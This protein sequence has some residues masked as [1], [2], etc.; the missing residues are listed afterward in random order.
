MNSPAALSKTQALAGECIRLSGLVQGVGMRPSIYRLATELQLRGDVA[1]CG[2]DVLIQIWAPAPVLELFLETLFSHLPPGSRIDQCERQALV[3]HPPNKFLIQDSRPRSNSGEVH[4]SGIIPDRAICEQCIAELFQSDNRRYHHPF[5]NCTSCGPRF[6]I[7]KAQTWERSNTSMQSFPLCSD[8]QLEFNSPLD[9]RFQAHA[10]ACPKC[11]PTLRYRQNTVDHQSDVIALAAA[12]IL[13][14][15]IV[16]IQGQGCFQL[17]CHA[18][19]EAAIARLR[20]LKQRAQKPFALM[21]ESPTD[22]DPYAY[23]SAAEQQLLESPAAPI[24]LLKTKMDLLASEI[25]PGLQDL[26]FMLANTALHHLILTVIK[27]PIVLTSANTSAQPPLYKLDQ[28]LQVLDSLCDGIVFHDRAIT[29]RLDDSVAQ[30]VNDVPRLLRRAR[31]YVPAATALPPGFEQCPPTLA[32]GGHYKSS[33]CLLSDRHAVLSAWIG[34]LN[35]PAQCEDYQQQLIDFSAMNHF[36]PELLTCDQHPD[37]F[38][39][40]QAAELASETGMKL[41]PVWHHHAHAA[42]CLAENGRALQSQPVLAVV[43]DGNGLGPDGTIWGGEFLLVDYQRFQRLG[44]ITQFPL[45]GGE[46]AAQQPWRSLLAQL[47]TSLSWSSLVDEFSDLAII[48]LLAAKPI[49]TLEGM[50]TSHTNSPLCSSVGRLFDAVAAALE[51]CFEKLSYEGEAAMK[52]QALAQQSIDQG[53]YPIA[54]VDSIDGSQLAFS[55]MWQALLNDLLKG[56][57][58]TDIARRFHNGLANAISAMAAQLFQ[59]TTD[60][61]EPTVALSGGVFQNALL[62]KLTI[63]SLEARG[64]TVLSHSL[65]PANDS[66]LAFGQAVVT[67]ARSLTANTGMNDLCA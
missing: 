27:G 55:T 61:Q 41:E 66:G 67:A 62:L 33:L 5:S 4:R 52:L 2:A 58:H 1:N 51:I 30:L 26:G 6:S 50:M 46:S 47:H 45:L 15:K 60:W 21:V 38:S 29:H 43:F 59:Q 39:S 44:H 20:K 10:T 53:S 31:G 65:I 7:L 14:G 40:T 24:V 18:R 28:A 49:R 48:K 35:S 63:K 34:D 23:Y 17:A 11:G 32:F 8:C 56:A 12:D 19:N 13:A 57:A 9:R 37:Y 54:V 42:A 22:I 36:K 64:F 3:G 16:A 25:A